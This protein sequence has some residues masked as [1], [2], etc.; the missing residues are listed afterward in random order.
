MPGIRYGRIARIIETH[1][2]TP[3]NTAM[4]VAEAIRR[5]EYLQGQVASFLG[6]IAGADQLEFADLHN[7]PRVHL[8]KLAK[9]FSRKTG[10]HAVLATGFQ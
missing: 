4:T 10:F 3:F 7:F 2:N 5:E 8:I 9:K 6:E 1:V